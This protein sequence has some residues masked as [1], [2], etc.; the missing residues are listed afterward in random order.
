MISTV[1][2]VHAEFDIA[3]GCKALR[4][5]ITAQ[6]WKPTVAARATAA[7]TAMGDLILNSSSAELVPINL[8]LNNAHKNPGINLVCNLYLPDSERPEIQEAVQRLGRAT[9]T[10]DI[11][12]TAG[13]LQITAHLKV[14]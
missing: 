2:L 3:R 6:N 14:V 7:L 1:I 5:H 11:Y 8:T 13:N 10:L 4:A 12:E 9:D